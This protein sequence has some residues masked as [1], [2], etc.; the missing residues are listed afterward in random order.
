MAAGAIPGAQR[1]PKGRPA[2]ST[3]YYYYYSPLSNRLDWCCCREK[4]SC[5]FCVRDR[6]MLAAYCTVTFF[7]TFL[8]CRTSIALQFTHYDGFC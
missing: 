4:A 3:I 7:N 8:Q 6:H 1:A 2:L 5:P